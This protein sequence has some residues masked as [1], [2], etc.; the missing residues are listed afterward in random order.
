MRAQHRAVITND[1]WQDKGDYYPDYIPRF[2]SNLIKNHAT[3]KRKYCAPDI[4]LKDMGLYFMKP[5]S[6]T[7]I[8]AE[9][10]TV[11]FKSCWL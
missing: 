6:N 11:S 8:V 3:V 1:S 2:C 7:L 10:S 5:L 9:H 4:C